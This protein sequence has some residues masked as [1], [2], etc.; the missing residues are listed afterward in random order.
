MLWAIPAVT[1]VALSFSLIESLLI[2]PSHL[3]QMKPEK[4]PSSEWGLKFYRLRQWF[5]NGM[6]S[7]AKQSYQPML[8]KALEWRYLTLSDLL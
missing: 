7:F 6:M 3:A 5:A 8:I 4:E 2:L 1:I